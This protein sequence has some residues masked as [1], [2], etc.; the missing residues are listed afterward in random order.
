M[1]YTSGLAAGLAY[2]EGSSLLH[3]RAQSL[4]LWNNLI[5]V[6]GGGHT[7]IYE[8]AAYAPQVN[9]FLN[10]S[11]ERL[12]AL[13]CALTSTDDPDQYGD[14][15]WSIAPNPIKAGA[16]L[17]VNLPANVS[18]STLALYDLSGRLLQRY[19]NVT[20]GTSLVLPADLSPGLKFLYLENV[21]NAP[22]IRVVVE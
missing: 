4:G 9:N 19:S 17:Q 7:D 16:S 6:T 1:S 12:E 3:A 14:R 21:R 22:M 11:C 2:L 15:F 5:T 18:Q 20:Q 10:V 13:T 8:Q